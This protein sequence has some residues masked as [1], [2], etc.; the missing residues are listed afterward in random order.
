[1]P[2]QGL[3]DMF[4]AAALQALPGHEPSGRATGWKFSTLAERAM[5]G[6]ATSTASAARL[7]GRPGDTARHT[8]IIR[9]TGS[10]VRTTPIGRFLRRPTV[11]GVLSGIILF[12]ILVGIREAGILQP[13]EL[14]A[15]DRFL[16]LHE[17]RPA[18]DQRIALLAIT[19][20]DIQTLGRWPLPDEDLAMMISALQD[21]RPD[22]IGID[23]YRDLPVPPGSEKLDA[24][25]AANSNVFA[26][27]KIGTAD[28]SGVPAPG[29]LA[30]TRQVGFS[31]LLVDPDGVVRRG[32]LFLDDG[33]DVFY[34]LSLRLAL[35]YLQ[36]RSIYPQPGEPEPSHMQLGDITLRPFEASDGGYVDAD[37]A[38]YQFM[39]D[40]RGGPQPFESYSLGELLGGEIPRQA[41]EDRIVI[42]GVAAE[43]VKDDFITPYRHADH[44]LPGVPGI[45]IHAHA[46]SQLLRLALDG[47][48]PKDVLNDVQEYIWTLFWMAAGVVLA[49]RFRSAGRFVPA[50]LLGT[51]LLVLLSYLAYTTGIWLPLVPAGIGWIA[52]AA[53]MTAYLTS[54]ENA[55]RRQIMELFSRQ[56]SADVARE[57]WEQRDNFMEGGRVPARDVVCTVLFSDLENFTPVSE[58]L[59]PARLMEWLNRYMDTMAGLVMEYGG[60]VDDY[61]GDA[62]MA[63]FGVPLERTTEAEYERDARNAVDCALA[64]R[65]AIEQ[66]NTVNAEQ[67]LPS[68]RMRVGIATGEMVVGFLGTSQRMKYTTIGDTVNTAAR[69]ES[70]GKELP[71][72]EPVEGAC[73]ILVTESTAR[74][75]GEVYLVES[76]GALVLKGK[77][78]P[79]DVY[80]VLSKEV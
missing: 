46:V 24:M 17:G 10:M 6:L 70:Y 41:L 78:E 39:M 38:G 58:K 48:R 37:A 8:G 68:V 21:Y 34:S 40:Y 73:R 12:V 65:A 23:I 57:I 55:Q 79:V 5:S 77:S 67:G 15:Y 61:F 43:S 71:P 63:D 80:K 36:S 25:L 54:Y 32:L 53:L 52:A 4:D 13:L 18:I 16:R 49:L 60:I 27:E 35:H 75:L 42:I 62:I 59:G 76:V 29:V 30:G 51:A 3:Q 64:M 72:M 11:F 20:A 26:V 9:N 47:D 50:A 44:G 33:N 74:R 69:L 31:D 1:M 28:V 7:P 66:L 19:E 56:V 45:T 2:W 14:G 22:S